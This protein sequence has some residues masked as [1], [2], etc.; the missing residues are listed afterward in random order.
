MYF[1]FK[2]AVSY[3][4]LADRQKPIKSESV[5]K[6]LIN[7][8]LKVRRLGAKAIQTW[9]KVKL[10]GVKVRLNNLMVRKFGV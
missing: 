7:L 5:S 9:L 8:G 3:A 10:F 6:K 1:K 4:D 2:L